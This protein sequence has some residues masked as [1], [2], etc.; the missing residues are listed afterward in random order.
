MRDVTTISLK[1]VSSSP[2]VVIETD[3]PSADISPCEDSLSTKTESPPTRPG[4]TPFRADSDN[5]SIGG[6]RNL[7]STKRLM[8]A[9]P[10]LSVCLFVSFLDQTSVATATPAMAGELDT[11]AATSWIGASFLIASTAFQLING[12]LSDIFGRKNLLLI[13]LALMGIGDLACGFSQTKEQLFVF[14]SIAGVGGGGINSLAMI[15]VSDIT[16]LQNRGTYQGKYK[17]LHEIPHINLRLNFRLQVSS[18][19]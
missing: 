18:V 15:I 9:I 2:S 16:T 17:F 8:I 4:Q 1:D 7:M 19:R 5:E 11:G 6:Q 3:A 14:R 13:C 12:R 10:A